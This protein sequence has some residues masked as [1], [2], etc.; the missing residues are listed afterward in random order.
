MKQIRQR[1]HQLHRHYSGCRGLTLIELLVVLVILVGV[2]GL[3]VSN[4]SK[5]VS[6]LGADGQSREAGEVVTLSSMQ[7]VRDALLGT[8]ATD[9]G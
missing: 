9:P 7:A 4:F 6:V 8:S 5:P 3:V 2:G 1:S